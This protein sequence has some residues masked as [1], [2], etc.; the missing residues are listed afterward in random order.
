MGYKYTAQNEETMRT[1]ETMK[2]TR[3]QDAIQNTDWTRT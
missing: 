2:E 1:N 3:Q